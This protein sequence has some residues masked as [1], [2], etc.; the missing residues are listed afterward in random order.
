MSLQLLFWRILM[1]HHVME[2]PHFQIDLRTFILFY[3]SEIPKGVFG[4]DFQN[5]K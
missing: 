4:F 2:S 3:W 1:S 5:K